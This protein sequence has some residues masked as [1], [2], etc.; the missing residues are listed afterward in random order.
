MC[1]LCSTIQYIVHT[2]IQIHPRQQQQ[3]QQRQQQLQQKKAEV[4][5]AAAK[6]RKNIIKQNK[7]Y[8]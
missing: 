8:N 3:L 4:A 5:V 2:Y 7:K 6:Q 1:V